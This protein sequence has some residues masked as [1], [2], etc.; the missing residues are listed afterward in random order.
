MATKQALRDSF[1]AQGNAMTGCCAG[2]G[3]AAG[4]LGVEAHRMTIAQR[5]PAWNA[6]PAESPAFDPVI[7][8]LDQSTVQLLAAPASGTCLQALAAAE[9][10][11]A[12][13]DAL[14]DTTGV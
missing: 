9:G 12:L 13:L 7:A 5:V 8:A 6:L 2:P 3:S 14:L 4:C 1:G 11:L 10:A